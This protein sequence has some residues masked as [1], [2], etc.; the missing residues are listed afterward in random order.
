MH[1]N[2]IQRIYDTTDNGHYLELSYVKVGDDGYG[3]LHTNTVT[4]IKID[5]AVYI[6]SSVGIGT[7]PPSCKLDVAGS[8]NVS[9]GYVYGVNGT[10]VVSSRKTGWGAPTGTATR[11]TFATNSVT[12]S[13]LAERVKALIDDLTTHGLIGS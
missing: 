10:Q 9:T 7:E 4:G 8:I 11:T 3:L 2:G 13:G 12:L 6:A 5:T 1:V